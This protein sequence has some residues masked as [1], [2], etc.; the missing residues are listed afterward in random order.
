MNKL[1]ERIAVLNDWYPSAGLIQCFK[2]TSL[3]TGQGP[4]QPSSDSMP[5]SLCP[6]GEAFQEATRLPFAG[7]S[8]DLIQVAGISERVQDVPGLLSEMARVLQPNG[9]ILL[10]EGLAPTGSKKQPRAAS[11]WLNAFLRLRDPAHVRCYDLNEWHT[12]LYQAGF[13]LD[14]QTETSP[15]LDFHEWTAAKAL[16]PVT[17]M[18]LQAMLVQAPAPVVAFLTPD[19][20]VDRITFSLPQ[21]D[22]VVRRR[23]RAFSQ[24]RA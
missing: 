10:R 12:M 8:F 4:L 2:R 16:P 19:I 18:R 11:R 9:Q 23:D 5:G 15:A 22:F 13:S 17:S 20:G 1:A 3:E 14:S 6:I 24:Q 21:V 7:E